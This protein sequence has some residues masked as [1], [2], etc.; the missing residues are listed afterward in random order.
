M[1]VIGLTRISLTATSTAGTK[2]QSEQRRVN[3]HIS[4]RFGAW[5][6]RMLSCW[7]EREESFPFKKPLSSV[8]HK[9]KEKGLLGYR[10]LLS[11]CRAK[12]QGSSLCSSSTPV[13]T[14]LVALG[15]AIYCLHSVCPT[16]KTTGLVPWVLTSLEHC[17]DKLRV[18]S[19]F[20]SFRGKKVWINSVRFVQ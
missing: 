5:L 15:K 10:T 3:T 6:A 1:Q 2:H 14:C 20:L 17:V 18:F 8:Q 4:G 11:G 7:P 9:T 12:G 19:F 13:P 16:A